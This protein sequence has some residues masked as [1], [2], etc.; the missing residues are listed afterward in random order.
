VAIYLSDPAT[1]AVPVAKGSATLLS[2]YN[3]IVS[4]PL[5]VSE[6]YI[7]KVS[8]DGSSNTEKLSL[9]SANISAS[10]SSRKTSGVI[11]SRKVSTSLINK[12]AEPECQ[13]QISTSS[14]RLI[15]N[16][17]VICFTSTVD[18]TI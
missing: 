13:T 1:G 7:V 9:L 16:T 18:V 11:G 17:D 8:P 10:L 14:I 5:I 6:A 12:T 15:S 4:I 3:A 2:P